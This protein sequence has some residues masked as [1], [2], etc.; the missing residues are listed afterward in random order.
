M[1]CQHL[2][3]LTKEFIYQRLSRQLQVLLTPTS[4]QKRK[5]K[6]KNPVAEEAAQNAKAHTI[7]CK[8]EHTAFLMRQYLECGYDVEDRRQVA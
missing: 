8:L 1:S 5:M 6:V 3:W 7:L 4:S 2:A